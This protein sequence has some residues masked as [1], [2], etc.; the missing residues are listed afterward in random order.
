MLPVTVADSMVYVVAGGMPDPAHEAPPPTFFAELTAA[1][2]RH[3]PQG[4]LRWNFAGA[5]TDLEKMLGRP[6]AVDPTG[7]PTDASTDASTDAPTDASTDASNDPAGGPAPASTDGSPGRRVVHDVVERH[8]LERLKPWVVTQA[9]AVASRVVTDALVGPVR[10]IDQGLASTVEAFR[11]LAARVEAVEADAERRRHPVEGIAWHV[12]ATPF[13]DRTQLAVSWLLAH[14]KDGP[15]VHAE[16]GDGELLAALVA[17]G[18]PALGIEPR[19]SVA[20]RA[21]EHQVVVRVGPVA[22]VLGE[23]GE[24]SAGAVVL[25]GVV[26]RLAVGDLVALLDLVHQRLAPGA[27]VMVAGTTPDAA[28]ALWDPVAWDLLPG[29][30]LH[31]ET[32]EVLLDRAGFTD[33]SRLD[34]GGGD[35]S[36]LFMV[37]GARRT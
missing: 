19:G 23:L 7:E 10:R 15:V 11:F 4:S 21:A 29:R 24:A 26:D 25:S 28:R 12:P 6:V 13:G 9:H 30:P 33:V 16:C 37:I 31:P 2:R 3:R 34:D 27:P 35:G 8:F 18:A 36:A 5:F 20:W 17:A 1:F 32:W 14:R 22:D